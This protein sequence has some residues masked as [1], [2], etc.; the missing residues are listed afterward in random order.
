LKKFRNV[1][2]ISLTPLM[3]VQSQN[4]KESAAKRTFVPAH[5]FRQGG[6]RCPESAGDQG[7]AAAAQEPLIVLQA[8]LTALVR[9]WFSPICRR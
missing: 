7:L 9:P 1:D 8:A 4:R 2:L 5:A 6:S 3:L